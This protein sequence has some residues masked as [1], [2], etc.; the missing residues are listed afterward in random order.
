MIIDQS[1]EIS[2]LLA[3]LSELQ[4]DIEEAKKN[5]SG[6]NNRYKFAELSQYIDIPKEKLKDLGLSVIQCPGKIE[7]IEIDSKE[8]LSNNQAMFHRIRVPKQTI[9]TRLGHKSGQYMDSAMDI[10]VE[11]LA[12][13]S[14]GQSTG[15]SI[16][17]ARK[18]SRAA[19][20]AMSQE[21]DDNQ[22]VKQDNNNNTH[23][24]TQQDRR[25]LP[26]PDQTG[27][28]SNQK[29]S[30]DQIKDIYARCNNNEDLINRMKIWAGIKEI[31]DLSVEKYNEA[32]PLIENEKKSMGGTA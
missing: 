19:A 17:Y 10:I 32:L 6:H 4:G 1:P 20:L 24:I 3:A 7:I 5:K 23:K 30:A 13:M 12:G 8:V 9:V 11:K 21:D 15:S 22:N 14:W 28:N 31:K 18:Y 26:N 29:V 2:E 27:A 25:S 16:T